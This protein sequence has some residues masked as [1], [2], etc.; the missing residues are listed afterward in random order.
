MAA[1]PNFEVVPDDNDD[2]VEPQQVAKD[3]SVAADL[4]LL[5]VKALSA[6][7]LVALSSMFSLAL[8]GSLFYLCWAALPQPSVYQI[9]LLT[10]Y[11]VFVLVLHI[12]RNRT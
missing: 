4:L 2:P 3:N 11:A 9:V 10:I 5:A 12:I 6:R 7:A 1:R 8:A